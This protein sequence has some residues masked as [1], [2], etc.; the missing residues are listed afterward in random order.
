MAS[1]VLTE[2]TSE[3][4]RRSA[5]SLRLRAF[6]EVCHLSEGD[7][8]LTIWSFIAT[9]SPTLS[10]FYTVQRGGYISGMD[11][12]G[13]SS[14]VFSV[15]PADGEDVRVISGHDVGVDGLKVVVDELE[16]DR[17]PM[18]ICTDGKMLYFSDAD[19][20]RGCV[21]RMSL[22]NGDGV[23]VFPSPPGQDSYYN[24]SETN[25]LSNGQLFMV[26]YG[27]HKL[28][29][30]VLPPVGDDVDRLVTDVDHLMDGVE[31]KPVADLPF[32]ASYIDVIARDKD[33]FQF[34]C[35]VHNDKE[36]DRS[37]YYVDFG[38][39]KTLKRYNDAWMCKFIPSHDEFVCVASRSPRDAF[40]WD[41]S[42]V[43]IWS[44]SVVCSLPSLT[45]FA[46]NASLG[47]Y[48]YL[49][50]TENDLVVL[51][52]QKSYLVDP[53]FDVVVSQLRFPMRFSIS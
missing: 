3:L 10:H 13:R 34:V 18:S 40:L 39:N 2:M 11:S 1:T 44:M 32:G 38:G 41:I 37:L 30:T 17:L 48:C 23:V 27:D 50:V 45:E 16:V 51:A 4:S 22:P 43:D 33:E 46:M 19:A 20:E 31:W 36:G 42:L 15:Q 52:Q 28:F 7:L 26:G 9:S 12:W 49:G 47:C 53:T 35:V 21:A 5:L 6:N 25:C 24:L 14:V 29:R 8:L